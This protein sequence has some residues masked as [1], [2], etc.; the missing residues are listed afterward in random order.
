MQQFCVQQSNFFLLASLADYM[1]PHT[2]RLYL[3]LRE[4]D[5]LVGLTPYG[6]FNFNVRILRRPTTVQKNFR[7][8]RSQIICTPAS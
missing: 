8:L 4:K 5:G 3:G 6:I 1:W 2:L 7:L